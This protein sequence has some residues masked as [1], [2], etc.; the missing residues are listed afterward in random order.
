MKDSTGENGCTKCIICCMRCCLD[1]FD[2]FIRYVNMNAYVY[3]AI[4]SEPFC[5]S[6]LHSFLLMLKNA[7]KFGFVEGLATMFMFMA[8]CCISL[9]TTVS[10]YFL[11]KVMVA[12]SVDERPLFPMIVVFFT[13]YMVASI[14]ISVFEACSSTILMCYLLDFD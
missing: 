11:L 14:F 7:A 2:R 10:C 3:C 6:A 12:D 4:S 8:K 9:F 5:S 1:C 13:S